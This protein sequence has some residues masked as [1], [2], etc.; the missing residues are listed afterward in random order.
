M[1]A[2]RP[3]RRVSST[4]DDG[5]GGQQQRSPVAMLALAAML[6]VGAMLAVVVTLAVGVMLAV[7]AMLPLVMGMGM[8]GHMV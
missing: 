7:V 6:A 4:A 3:A 2:S 1:L 8:G 5:V